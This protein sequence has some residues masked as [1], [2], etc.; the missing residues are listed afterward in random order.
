MMNVFVTVLIP[1]YNASK[2]IGRAIHS[3]LNQTYSNFEF[4]VINDGSTDDTLNI[5]NSFH[6]SRLRIIDQ[7]N[8]GKVRSLNKGIRLAK[9]SY[10]AMLDADDESHYKRLEKQIQFCNNNPGIEVVGTA[11]KEVY[12]DGKAKIRYRPPNNREMIKSIIKICPITHS[13]A[14]IKKGVF[15][16]VGLYDPAKDGPQKKAIGED[17]DMWI[18]MLQHG[19]QMANMDDVLTTYYRLPDSSIGSRTVKK[20]IVQRLKAR[21][22]AMQTLNL[23]IYNYMFFVPVLV[24]SMLEIF[25]F[26]YDDIFNLISKDNING[27]GYSKP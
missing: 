2:T 8:I 24:L 22:E 14:M 20:K 5:V 4:I 23:P 13:S 6:D 11:T 21:N 15:D 9:G 3:I 27:S 26:K 1:A 18:R 25:N 16:V 7:K 10:I 19:I 12:Y 17:Y